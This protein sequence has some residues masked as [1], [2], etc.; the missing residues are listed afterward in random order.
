MKRQP[1]IRHG[2]FPERGWIQFLILRL[3]YDE[4]MHGYQLIQNL[5]NQG[6]VTP[7]RFRT[8]SIYTI[9]K[10]MEHRGLLSSKEDVSESRRIRKQYNITSK[11]VDALKLG[12]MGVLKRKKILDDLA[13]FYKETFSEEDE[14]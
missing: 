8:G 3:L 6:F 2:R 11:G 14:I 9:L 7:G 10:R 12:L 13:S 4:P 5:E 1:H